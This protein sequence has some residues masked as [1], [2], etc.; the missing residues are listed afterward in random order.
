MES[1]GLSYLESS[2][3][4]ETH[5]AKNIEKSLEEWENGMN[6]TIFQFFSGSVSQVKKDK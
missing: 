2:W 3:I 4:Y 1:S 6:N 5:E